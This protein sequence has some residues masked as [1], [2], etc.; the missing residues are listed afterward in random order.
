MPDSRQLAPKIGEIKRIVSQIYKVEKQSLEHAKRGKVNEPRNVAI[1]IARK[2]SGLPLEEIGN[3]FG[4]EKYS[5]VS[6]IVC[7]TEQ[8]LSK[9]EKLRNLVDKVKR[10][11]NKSQAKA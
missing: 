9:N 10:E 5:S 6:S 1:Y 4:L 8:Q 2:R 11:L 3:E 7:R